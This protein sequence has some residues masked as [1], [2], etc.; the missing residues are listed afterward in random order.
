VYVTFTNRGGDLGVPLPGG[1]VRLYKNDAGGTSQF[2]GSDQID[3]TPRNEDVRLHL[4]D[5]FDVTAN[6][7][8][9]TFRAIGG[10]A[11]ASSYRVVLANAKAEPAT[12]LVVEP[13]PGDW[14]ITSENVRHQ[15]ASS[16]TASWSM[17][18]PAG[19]KAT[20]EY[21]VRVKLCI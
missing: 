5:S 12:V 17:R 7:K 19:G 13:I 21:G 2:L 16:A 20:L 11:F 9:L 6:K 14:Q 18:V 8:Q 4:G 1:V 3:H 15:K 10:C